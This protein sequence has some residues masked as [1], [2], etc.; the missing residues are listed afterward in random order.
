MPLQDIF[1]VLYR[2]LQLFHHPAVIFRPVRKDTVRTVADLLPAA[3]DRD[4][5]SR[6]LVQK[7]QGAVAEQAVK[8]VKPLMA[9]KIPAVP[10]FK[11]SV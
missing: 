6:T 2:L 11:K 9:G 7:I 3:F 8:I 10:V 1:A 5:R 4:R